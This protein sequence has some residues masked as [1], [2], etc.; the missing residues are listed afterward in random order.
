VPDPLP[1]P[2]YRPTAPPPAHPPHPGADAHVR[3]ILAEG[4]V[5]LRDVLSP[6]E[7]AEMRAA[8]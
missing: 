8:L 4:F 6:A 7:V 3:A 1:D 2:I 5:V